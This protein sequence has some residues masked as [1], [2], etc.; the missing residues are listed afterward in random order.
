MHER[1]M[2]ILLMLRMMKQFVKILFTFMLDIL[3]DIC[4]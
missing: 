1:G 3:F 2:Q 4:N